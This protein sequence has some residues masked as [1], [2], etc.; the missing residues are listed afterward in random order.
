MFH[1]PG[2]KKLK[3]VPV[4]EFHLLKANSHG[5]P[6]RVLQSLSPQALWTRL[7]LKKQPLPQKIVFVLTLWSPSQP[8]R[9]R[10]I[11]CNVITANVGPGKL[12]LESITGY[13]QSKIIFKAYGDSQVQTTNQ[14]TTKA[15]WPGCQPLMW[16]NG[17][18]ARREN[19]TLRCS[20]YHG[21]LE[22]WVQLPI[23]KQTLEVTHHCL[24][25]FKSVTNGERDSLSVLLV[26]K[27]S[28]AL[29]SYRFV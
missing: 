25:C 7:A 26:L 5:C 24:M 2:E 9:K 14:K 6:G 18:T 3:S 8:F 4:L 10:T 23:L 15:G 27:V 17:R 12:T 1:K 28:P 21:N 20:V 13:S 22:G 11:M 16:A 19:W 29:D